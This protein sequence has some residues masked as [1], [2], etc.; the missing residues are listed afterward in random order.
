MSYKQF[1]M[2]LL[3]WLA[4]FYR[5]VVFVYIRST[6]LT[7]MRCTNIIISICAG[8]DIVLLVNNIWPTDIHSI[9]IGINISNIGISV[10]VLLTNQ[11]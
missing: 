2:L 4:L 1:T 11:Y 5:Q 10:K 3:I 9:G 8:S 7:L 6:Y